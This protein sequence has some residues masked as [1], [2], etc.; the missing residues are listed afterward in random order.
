MSDWN[1]SNY[2]KFRNERT[3]PS[4]DL[5]AR[6][7]LINPETIADLGCGPGNSTKILADKWPSAKIVG[8]DNSPEMIK[9]ARADFPDITWNLSDISALDDSN[10]YDIVFSNATLQWLP[11]HESL[12]PKLFTLISLGGV[13]A[14]QAPMNQNA[15]LHRALLR[16]AQSDRWRKF[17][18]DCDCLV[19]YQSAS[20]YYQIL[21]ALTSNFDLW[22]TTYIHVLENHRGLIEWY[23][24]TGMRPYLSALPDAAARSQFEDEVLEICKREY[25]VQ[26]NG[27]VLYPFSRAFFIACKS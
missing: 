6:I 1:P 10:T 7:N 2:L 4:I 13:L 21:D 26:R 18:G 25:P 3:Q 24:S 11:D 12:I 8:I 15:P 20:Y 19:N 14:V 27:K 22:E 5:A 16:V 9:K 23:K 17:T